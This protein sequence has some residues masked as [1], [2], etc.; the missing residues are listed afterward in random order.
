MQLSVII[1]PVSGNGFRAI[2]AG[3]ETLSADGATADEALENFRELLARRL[4]AGMRVVTVELPGSES[5]W[6]KVAG[7]YK[8][9]PLFE[10]WRQAMAD[11]RRQ[12]DDDPDSP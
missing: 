7:I 8:D 4:A 9:D 10:E 12:I 3:V 11:Y 5:P 6:T 2:G 1:E